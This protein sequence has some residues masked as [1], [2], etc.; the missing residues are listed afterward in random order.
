M[1]I[2]FLRSSASQ[3]E[4]NVSKRQYS[5]AS[6]DQKPGFHVFQKHAGDRIHLKSESVHTHYNYEEQ[7]GLNT[8]NAANIAIGT[9]SGLSGINMP[10]YLIREFEGFVLLFTNL[11]Q[12]TTITGVTSGVLLHLRSYAKGSLFFVISK[13]ITDLFE[14]GGNIEE[15]S[16]SDTPD[17][18]SCLRD[19]KSNWKMCKS[20][21]IF[22]QFSKLLGM[23]VILGL[24]KHSDVEF[25]IGKFKMFTP[26]LYDRHVNAFELVD[27]LCET[28][29]Y[30]V[31]SAYM[32]FKTRSIQPLL[33]NDHSALALDEECAKI[34]SWWDLVK[35]GNLE[36]LLQIS[37]QEFE[38]RLNKLTIDLFKLSQS[39]RGLDKKLVLDKYTKCLVMQND[40][41]T[42][43]MSSG[44]RHAPFAIELFGE[45]SQGKTTLGDQLVDALLTS[46]SL[47]LDKSYRAAYNAGDKYM[48]NWTS[49]KLVMIF[50]D[51]S[52]EKSQFVERPPTRA[53][54]DVCNNQ[55]YYANKAELE[56][57][58]KCFV[59]PWIV[60]ATTNIKD[61]DAS[62]YSNCPYSIQ[63][64]LIVYSVSVKREFQR[65]VEGVT[66]G[67]DSAKVRQHYT[68]DG[69]YTP[70][71][72]D[73][74]WKITIEQAVKPGDLKT[75][76]SYESVVW[77]GRKMEDID[78]ET[79][80]QFS[81]EA[82]HAHRINQ[83]AILDGMRT[84]SRDLVVCSPTCPHIKG[85]CPYHLGEQFGMQTISSLSRISNK[86]TQQFAMHRI[87]H[88]ANRLDKVV[89]DKI[90]RHGTRFLQKWH[91]IKVVPQSAMNHPWAKP[92]LYF[93]YEDSLKTTYMQ[94]TAATWA[95]HMI[96]FMIMLV[97]CVNGYNSFSF[98]FNLGIVQ[99]IFLTLYQCFLLEKVENQLFEQLRHSNDNVSTIVK[100][101]RDDNAK[102]V[103]GIFFGLAA[104]YALARAYRAWKAYE[105]QGTLTPKTQD[106][107]NKRDSEE[108]PWSGEYCKVIA[109]DIHKHTTTET[110][111]SGV[112]KKNTLHAVVRHK[113]HDK[114]G[115]ANVLMLRSNLLMIPEHYF[116]HFGDELDCVFSQG[117]PDACG[118]KFRGKISKLTSHL[119]PE[120]DMR[121]CYIANGG[122]F[123][124]IVK[125]FP[126]S[127]PRSVPFIMNW[128][129]ADG[130][131]I[132][133]K[134]TTSPQVV[135]TRREF[136]GGRYINLSDN[137]F[138][139]LCGATLVSQTNNSHIVGL[140]LGGATGLPQG[141]YG[142]FTQSEICDAI[143]AIKVCDGVMLTGAAGNFSPVQFD[144]QMMTNLKTATKSP[145]NY[146]PLDNQINYMGT[147]VGAA[148]YISAVSVLPTSEHVA[149]ICGE[150]NIYGPPKF[151]PDWFGW[152]QCLANMS[153]PAK[154]FEHDLLDIAIKDYKEPL[155]E[156]A[157][158]DL[159]SNAAPLTTKENINGIPGVKFIDAIKIDTAIGYPLIGPKS[160]FMNNVV[161]DRTFNPIIM[162]EIHRCEALYAKGERA[163]TI[164]KACKK[165]EILS[166]EKC[167]IFFGNSIALTFLIRKYYLPILRILQMN[168]L[169][170]EC[171]VGINSHGPEWD[172][173]Y[174]HSTKFGMDRLIGGDY[175]KYDQKLPCQLL[176]ASM[177]ILIDMA[178]QCKYDQKDIGIME[179]LAG[180]LVYAFIAFNGDLIA[181]TE[182]SHISGNS[183]TVILNGICGSLNMRCYYYHS[184]I[185]LGVPPLQ[186]SRFRQSVALMTYG[187]DNIG[188]VSSKLKGFT[189]EGMAHF[190]AMYG[191]TYTMPDK[192]SALADFLHP[193]Q[194]DF[195]KRSNV[196][197]P[198]ID[199][200][201]GAL[202]EKSI[203]K[204]LHCH[205]RV[206]G[207]PNTPEMAA[208]VNID[209]ALSEWFNHG[210]V[211][212]EHR[213]NQMLKVARLAGIDH[214]CKS[215]DVSFDDRTR[216][217]IDT[218][219]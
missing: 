168:P 127:E 5:Y 207:S 121:V 188:T 87:D 129:Q 124:D 190:L 141:C 149:D 198:E 84:R 171:A 204:M 211:T 23:C 16:G 59:E 2:M 13:Y 132:H 36:K 86:V 103:C 112:I 77:N 18:L 60:V 201:I 173:F 217:W 176:L 214:M 125:H 27:A 61:L 183:L 185:A 7:F 123:R 12:Q 197:I 75:R 50:D 100:K 115:I 166:K 153:Q 172:E 91:W 53:I 44:V 10:D 189:I 31:E 66:C 157:S 131:F 34:T 25:S 42:M 57:K 95:F 29:T 134:G 163:Y 162:N 152:Q 138:K 68:V 216:K 205:M 55:M 76:A 165:D 82:F 158:S 56:A 212:Y 167:R 4:N 203:F 182:G 14:P 98:L 48:S 96:L 209:T 156:L 120:S 110:S 195:L 20:N 58:G 192:E 72:F 159:W 174:K 117:N 65:V 64:R 81:I 137:T 130:T 177:R 35:V 106:D 146:L 9:L 67:I 63:R 193:D 99:I 126:D 107:V 1:I 208:A 83:A 33:I 40:F 136:K 143:E 32:C 154:E 128:R 80:I 21:K 28:V 89:S 104:I 200:N 215:L 6:V 133:F 45:S 175:G 85:Y 191:Q 74:I 19:V 3:N 69:V 179:A 122:S 148:T 11:S 90:Y 78:M 73:D 155:I 199:C 218:Y 88:L 49:D 147:C 51:C 46:A 94:Q 102:Y 169:V 93:I 52:N 105:P 135:R 43:K 38:R 113:D 118:G 206:R 111:L 109:S 108:S 140:H 22:A 26:D 180:D 30:F 41:V 8:L 181:L 37:D 142:S 62:L 219:E 160:R 170:S 70:P 101:C 24:C 119:I 186:I 202:S 139:G 116:D 39:L 151:K 17:W 97:R 161:G 196:Y 184:Q 47:P 150:P 144:V 145:M 92:I 54:L 71:Q 178:R 114:A 15:Q 164:A 194:F 187:D 210:R 213:R 79:C